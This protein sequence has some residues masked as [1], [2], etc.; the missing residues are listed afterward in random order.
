MRWSMSNKLREIFSSSLEHDEQYKRI[1]QELIDNKSCCL[2]AN[3]NDEP[4]YEM[5]YNAGTDPYCTIFNELRI[6]EN[7][8]QCLFWKL[9]KSI[10]SKYAESTSPHVILEHFYSR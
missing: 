10:R 2:C 5:G 4:H 3:A 7:G 9:R 1:V 8:Q 6:Y